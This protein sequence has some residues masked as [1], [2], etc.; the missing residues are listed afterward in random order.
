MLLA[1]MTMYWTAGTT[2][3][4]ALLKTSFAVGAQKW[5]WLAFFASFAVKLPM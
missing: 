1:I 4:E 3:I 5:L 2:D